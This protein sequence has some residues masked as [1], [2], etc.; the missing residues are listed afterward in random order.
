MMT[1]SESIY[2][3]GQ[4]AQLDIPFKFTV[5]ALTNAFCIGQEG[6]CF[7]RKQPYNKPKISQKKEEPLIEAIHRYSS[8]FW[9]K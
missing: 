3:G 6:N 8:I 7:L 5:Y 2:F 9:L 1:Q 4:I